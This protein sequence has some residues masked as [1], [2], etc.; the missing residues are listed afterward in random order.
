[1]HATP[2]QLH[3]VYK[4]RILTE[5]QHQRGLSLRTFTEIYS[6]KWFQLHSL[7]IKQTVDGNLNVILANERRMAN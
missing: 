3:V 5:T 7:G 2:I 1:M 4:C 6:L